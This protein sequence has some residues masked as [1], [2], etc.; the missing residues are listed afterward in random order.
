MNLFK[1]FIR[2]KTICFFFAL[3]DPISA[4]F[5]FNK[6]NEKGDLMSINMHGFEI[7]AIG[8][9]LIEPLDTSDTI[10]KTRIY[11]TRFPFGI[12]VVDDLA[13]LGNIYALRQYIKLPKPAK[14]YCNLNHPLWFIV[15][16]KAG[17]FCFFNFQEQKFF[18]KESIFSNFSYKVTSPSTP[19]SFQPQALP[20]EF[21]LFPG[22][23]I[24][25]FIED[26]FQTEIRITTSE[27]L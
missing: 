8:I 20:A 25:F 12:G 27:K 16:I 10:N 21:K 18:S 17:C 15:N 3:L 26:Y 5:V 2:L 4:Y 23:E 1:F 22:Q 7:P 19:L 13:N 24:S 11:A 6:N 9:E 14:N